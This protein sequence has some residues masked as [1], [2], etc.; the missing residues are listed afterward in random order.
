MKKF[1]LLIL[2]LLLL[3]PAIPTYA[4]TEPTQGTDNATDIILWAG[5]NITVSLTSANITVADAEDAL[6]TAAEAGADIIADTMTD[7]ANTYLAFLVVA[8]LIVVIFKWGGSV[9]YGLGV[10]VC[11]IYGF[12]TAGSQTVGSPLWVASVAIGILGF[13]FLYEIAKEPVARLIRRV[14]G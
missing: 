9:L 5:D 10:P 11:F 1:S 12:T 8:F 3:I 2:L 6:T 14:R 7:I 13:Y 4:F